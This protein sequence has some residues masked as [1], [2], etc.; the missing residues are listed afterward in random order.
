[1]YDYHIL[2]KIRNIMGNILYTFNNYVN[3]ILLQVISYVTPTGMDNTYA[4]HKT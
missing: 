2:C 4:F 1:M 3:T